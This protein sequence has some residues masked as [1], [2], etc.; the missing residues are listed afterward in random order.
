MRH[1]SHFG[2]TGIDADDNI[3]G[4]D[5]PNSSYRHNSGFQAQGAANGCFMQS[6]TF[7]DKDNAAA[8]HTTDAQTRQ[9][10]NR[11]FAIRSLND[12]GIKIKAQ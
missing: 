8:F 11:A 7:R 10:L 5:G 4:F 9:S 3:S 6:R 12:G 1:C 2:E